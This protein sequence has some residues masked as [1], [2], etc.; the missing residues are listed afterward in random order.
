MDIFSA[1]ILQ[2]HLVA[3]NTITHLCLEVDAEADLT[4][5]VVPLSSGRAQFS[6]FPPTSVTIFSLQ[7][8]L[9]S[10]E[11]KSWP[12]GRHSFGSSPFSLLLRSSH[13]HQSL[14]W[15]KYLH[16]YIFGS[17]LPAHTYPPL[18]DLCT[19]YL[20]RTSNSTG[21]RQNSCSFPKHV[22]FQGPLPLS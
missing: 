2:D 5:C 10:Q 13:P 6:S 21:I 17:E 12:C 11:V 22:I 19:W 14:P 4:M 1:L 8:P 7:I 15:A 16:A 3:L 18:L 20:P 9:P